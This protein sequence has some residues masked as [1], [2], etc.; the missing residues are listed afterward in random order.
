MH[1]FSLIYEHLTACIAYLLGVR[2]KNDEI[3]FLSNLFLNDSLMTPGYKK[4][5]ND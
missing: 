2:K 1:S 3:Q 5:N 4:K